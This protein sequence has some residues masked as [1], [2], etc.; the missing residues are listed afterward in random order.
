MLQAAHE[1]GKD[2][3]AAIVEQAADPADGVVLVV[4]HA[5]GARNKAWS[6]PCA[7]PAAPS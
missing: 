5:G 4:Q 6:T 7:R 3:A 2:L 1:T